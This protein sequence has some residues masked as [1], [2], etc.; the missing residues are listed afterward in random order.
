MTPR[1]PEDKLLDDYLDDRSPL[2][3][4][5][6]TGSREE[7]PAAL[8]AA[9]LAEARRALAPRPRRWAIPLSAA[10]AIL[11]AVG[12]GI[13]MTREG[14]NPIAPAPVS[15]ESTAAAKP[16]AAAPSLAPRA[17]RRATK[18][19]REEAVMANKPVPTAP[20]A[21]ATTS[22]A[23]NFAAESA[24]PGEAAKVDQGVVARKRASL[25]SAAVG[26][27]AAARAEVVSVVASGDPGAYR[28]TVT[29][30]ST[31]RG[32]AEYADWWEVVS[33]DGR[34]LYRRVLDHSHVD[35]Q[36]FSREGGPVPVAA[37]A[38][39]WVRAHMHPGGYL[40]GALRGSVKRGFAPAAPAPGFAAA[41][42]DEDP[43]PGRCGF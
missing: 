10:A 5:Y 33:E 15:P 1:K 22:D 18:P 36:P 21:V 19:A 4:M 35:E 32:C 30:R 24:A 41:L 20:A 11:L 2:S 13:V 37:D 7:P 31:D 28:F 23:A 40:G 16:E 26:G 3:G 38:V 14:V 9:I 29:V 6:R 42:A 12:L 8:D 34:L 25:R 27:I 43:K 17:D 39:V